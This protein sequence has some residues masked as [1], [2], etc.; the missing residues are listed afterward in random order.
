M[1]SPLPY[2][3]SIE[4]PRIERT[5]IHD[6]QAIL[7][8]TIAAVICGAESW[9]DIQA[10]GKA[11]QDWLTQHVE[12]EN[13]IPSHDTINRVISLLDP[14][15][16]E[17]SFLN[18]VR[19]EAPLNQGDIISIDG[20]AIRGSAQSNPHSFIHMVSAWSQ[21]NGLSL[22]Q[23]KVDEKSNEI[24]AIPKLLEI[25]DIEG[26]TITIDAMGCQ[27][28]IAKQIVKKKASYI[29]AVKGNQ[30]ELEENI[31]ASVKL[32][33]P[34]EQWE[35]TDSGHGRVETRTCRIYKNL[36][37]IR[38]EWDWEDLQAIVEIESHRHHKSNG[39]QEKETRYYITNLQ[40]TAQTIGKS[41]RNHWGIENSLH[42]ALDVSFG[43]DASRKREGNAAENY[44]RILRIALNL[45]KND[46]NKK[47]SL[48][49]KRLDAGWNN[50]YLLRLL[51]N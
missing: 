33:D 25:L 8:L 11:K 6:L 12:L 50:D 35:E 47:R 43:E 32:I 49:G 42:W 17:E 14:R 18:W 23:I 46:G 1:N 38:R 13:G 16:L 41:I 3:N 51:K 24:T 5:K 2:L 48:K 26:S 15:Q 31:K 30:K 27:K 10:F 19:N 45:L 36:S 22:G 37:L 28:S 44:S 9:N 20:K 34:N 21:T 40:E 29:L 7:F 4:D 39:K